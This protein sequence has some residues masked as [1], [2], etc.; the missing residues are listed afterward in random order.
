MPELR[1]DPI[2]GTWVIISS[3]RKQR[4]KYYLSAFE[5]DLST[6]ATCPFCPGNEAMTPREIAAHRPGGGPADGPGW[7]WRVFPNK[8]PA[9]RVEGELSES[10]EGFFNRMNGIGTHEVIVETPDH[11]KSLAALEPGKLQ[12]VLSV[13]RER[14]IDL[15][16]D[17]RFR[18]VMIFKNKGA[19]AGATIA[20]SHSQLVALPVIPIRVQEELLGAENYFRLKERCL[21]CDII[22]YEGEA[23]R[24]LLCENDCFTIMAPYAPRFPFEFVLYPKKHTPAFESSSDHEL[25]AL[26]ELLKIFLERIDKTLNNPDYNLILHNSPFTGNSREYY[27]WHFEFAPILTRVAGFEWGSGFYINPV[28]PEESVRALKK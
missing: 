1:K 20:H 24:R 21:F 3:E 13:F 15:Q 7:E 19:A 22:N 16:R 14:I 18:Y 11:G 25:A 26:A 9:L 5:Q 6:P 10:A 28:S 17:S 8:Y 27:H 23:N 4:P 2:T 12:A